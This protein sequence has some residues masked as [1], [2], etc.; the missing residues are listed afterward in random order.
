MADPKP[1]PTLPLLR[2]PPEIRNAIYEKMFLQQAPIDLWRSDHLSEE[3]DADLYGLYLLRG[4]VPG[5][6][7]LATSK[8]LKGEASGLLYSGNTFRISPSINMKSKEAW[9]KEIGEN[10]LLLRS[11]EINQGT[12]DRHIDIIPI[13][14]ELWRRTV[15]SKIRFTCLKQLT[16]HDVKPEILAPSTKANDLS[17]E[18]SPE[19]S[20][21]L[22]YLA[23]SEHTVFAA[24]VYSNHNCTNF[25]L[26]TNSGDLCRGQFGIY[27][28]L[29]SD[30]KLRFDTQHYWNWPEITNILHLPAM[31]KALVDLIPHSRKPGVFGLDSRTLSRPWPSMMHVNR[32]MRHILVSQFIKNPRDS[33]S[34]FWGRREANECKEHYE[35]E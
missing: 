31:Q 26:S 32:E 18:L 6:A 23:R 24:R 13:L 3:L 22:K 34:W 1:P 14:R 19:V 27:Y 4:S 20:P 28:D 12:W 29:A 9:M 5:I 30:G 16:A 7:F 21:Q 25:A 10:R 33:P 8:Q 35:A 11:I 17:L 15:T 2:C